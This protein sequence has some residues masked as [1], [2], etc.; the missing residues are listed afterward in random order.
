M[1][2]KVSI[3]KLAKVALAPAALVVTAI[4]GTMLFESEAGANNPRPSATVTQGRKLFNDW[5]CGSCH[6]LKDAGGTGHIGPKLD[7]AKLSKAFV[8]SRV[9]NG[10]GAMPGYAG[11]LTKQEIDVLSTYIAAQ[12][13][14]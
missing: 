8:V 11:M 5:S 3:G 6:I 14:R 13:S 4:T 9:A 7:G 12:S 2:D 1:D 10:Q